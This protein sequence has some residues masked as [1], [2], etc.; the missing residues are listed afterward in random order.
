MSRTLRWLVVAVVTYAGVT[1]LW[2]A[3]GGRKLVTTDPA[4]APISD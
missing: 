1:L 2:T 3:L 4:A